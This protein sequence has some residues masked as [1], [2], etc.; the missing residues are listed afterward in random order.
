MLF[1]S[2]RDLNGETLLQAVAELLG[3]PQR[4]AAIETAIRREARPNACGQIVD[5]LESLAAGR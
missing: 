5:E 2:D 3:S 1:R 4:L